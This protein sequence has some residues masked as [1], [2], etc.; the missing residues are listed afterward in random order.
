MPFGAGKYRAGRRFGSASPAERAGGECSSGPAITVPAPPI[1]MSGSLLVL[2]AG[3]ST[4]KYAAYLAQGEGLAEIVRGKLEGTDPARAFALLDERLSA[5]APGER[6]FAVGH[7]VVHGGSRF[8]RRSPSTTRSPTSSTRS[9]RSTLS[10]RRRAWPPSRPPAR[11][12]P[13]RSTSP[14]STPRFTGATPRSPTRSRSPAPFARPASAGTGS[15]AS[16]TSTSRDASGKSIP[17]P[18][19]EGPWSRISATARASVPSR[20]AEASTPR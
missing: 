19:G 18:P 10:T 11:I 12:T 3:S 6:P 2:N 15:T 8:G 13:T 14:A 9:F 17:W 20:T 1:T 16:P 7:R 4:L 5:A